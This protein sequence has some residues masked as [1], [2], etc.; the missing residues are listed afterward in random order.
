[1]GKTDYTQERVG[2]VPWAFVYNY[3]SSSLLPSHPVFP[4]DNLLGE[5]QRG[6]HY[7]WLLQLEGPS[8][9]FFK[10]A[11]PVQKVIAGI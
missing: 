5:S 3:A 7:L 4:W 11:K 6:L 2:G 1:M 9:G 10:G 8:Y